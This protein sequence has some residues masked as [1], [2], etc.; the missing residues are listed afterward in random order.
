MNILSQNYENQLAD[1]AVAEQKA[2]QNLERFKELKLNPS[3]AKPDDQD[4]LVFKV[5]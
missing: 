5:K 2:W 4:I 3:L 1:L